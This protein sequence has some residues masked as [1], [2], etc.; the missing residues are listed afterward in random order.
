LTKFWVRVADI[1][2]QIPANMPVATDVDLSSPTMGLLITLAT[3]IA[4]LMAFG[5]HLDGDWTH[6][7][8]LLY[9]GIAC[10]GACLAYT[11]K[12]N[13]QQYQNLRPMAVAMEWMALLGSILQIGSMFLCASSL[14]L[15][16]PT[17]AHVALGGLGIL[18]IGKFVAIGYITWE[19]QGWEA[20]ITMGGSGLGSR[21]HCY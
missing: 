2:W 15:V 3:V 20:G 1:W 21:D 8:F 17:I 19:D 7:K 16:S 13:L 10:F 14:T 6:A 9:S 18:H 4:G 11:T 12:N 5:P